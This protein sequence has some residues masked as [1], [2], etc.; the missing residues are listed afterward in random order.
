MIPIAPSD[1]IVLSS[2]E[3]DDDVT[4]PSR[5]SVTIEN[6]I[7]PPIPLAQLTRQQTNKPKYPHYKVVDGTNF[8]VDA[9][10]FGEIAGVTTYFLT[11]FHSDHYVGLNENFN[12][13]IYMSTITGKFDKYSDGQ[14]WMC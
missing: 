12:R 1:V 2:S 8:A 3:E 6:V 7:P 14:N 9:F 11:H 13:P 4:E 5:P 10:R